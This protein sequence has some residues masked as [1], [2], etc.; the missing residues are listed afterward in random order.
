MD[1]N[2]TLLAE[3]S[4]PVALP[5]ATT[6]KERF[7]G[8]ALYHVV[9]SFL[10]LICFALVFPFFTTGIFTISS[11]LFYSVMP[12]FGI[13]SMALYF[14]LGMRKAKQGHWTVPSGKELC[15]A[16][17]LPC[18]ISVSWVF[19]FPLSNELFLFYFLISA[20]FAAPSSLFVIVAI[21][22]SLTSDLSVCIFAGLFAAVLPPL[23][24]ALGSFWQ[25]K[26]QNFS[27]PM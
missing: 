21:V 9:Y 11:S 15:L 10:F 1:E 26:R 8:F 25:A 18:L 22:L 20:I 19:L 13:L 3:V 7:K 2:G 5:P 24:F 27:S 16:V 17:L 14:P 6:T 23:L 4:E 12:L